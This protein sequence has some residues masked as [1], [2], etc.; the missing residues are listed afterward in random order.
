MRKVIEWPEQGSARRYPMG[1]W[2]VVEETLNGLFPVYG[3]FRRRVEA[4][5]TQAIE[6]AFVDL[7][8]QFGP[9]FDEHR[10]R[11]ACDPTHGYGGP[12]GSGRED[13]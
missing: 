6:D 9:R 12:A 10:F 8:R 11:D 4:E 1:G 7:F 5:N 13:I 3:P 2:W